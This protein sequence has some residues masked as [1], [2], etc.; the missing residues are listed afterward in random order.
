MK[1]RLWM[2]VHEEVSIC[3]PYCIGSTDIGKLVQFGQIIQRNLMEVKKIIIWQFFFFPVEV[4]SSNNYFVLF[5]IVTYED[6]TIEFWGFF[7]FKGCIFLSYIKFTPYTLWPKSC[8]S[9]VKNEWKIMP[10]TYKEVGKYDPSKD[11][12]EQV[13][14]TAFEKA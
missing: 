10:R 1:N 2:W 7:S 9:N 8:I 6:M 4:P 13:I 11:K 12:A 3:S 14:E 5:L